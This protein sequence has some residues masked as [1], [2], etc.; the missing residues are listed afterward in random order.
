MAMIE[1]GRTA[2]AVVLAPCRRRRGTNALL[3]H[4]PQLI[5][6]TFGPDSFEAH[7]QAAQAL[8]LE[9]VI[10]ESPAVAFDLDTPEDWAE[11]KLK[12][13]SLPLGVLP[14]HLFGSTV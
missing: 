13:A 1:L 7:R 9:P 11:L 14:C 12:Q 10:Y 6:F 3:L 8:G 2:P 5:P 4:P